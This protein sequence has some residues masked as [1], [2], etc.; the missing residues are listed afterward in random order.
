MLTRSLFIVRSLTHCEHWYCIAWEYGQ[1][2]FTVTG[3][4]IF[5]FFHKMSA[6]SHSVRLINNGSSKEA[7]S[8]P[9]ISWNS[10]G[11]L[12]DLEGI[13]CHKQSQWQVLEPLVTANTLSFLSFLLLV[14]SCF[15]S[16]RSWSP[17]VDAKQIRA[18]PLLTLGSLEET[19]M[20]LKSSSHC[21]KHTRWWTGKLGEQEKELDTVYIWK[22]GRDRYTEWVS[23]NNSSDLDS[24]LHSFSLL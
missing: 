15:T 5:N 17:N 20:I 4:T 22:R 2:T 9:V 13:F 24:M 21:C 7:P 18:E 1:T 14:T 6:S 16:P 10:W 3:E 12:Q 8:L 19:A 11:T 23:T